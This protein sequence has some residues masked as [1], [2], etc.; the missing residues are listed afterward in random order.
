MLTSEK[1]LKMAREDTRHV[2]KIL[3]YLIVNSIN[4]AIMKKCK[5]FLLLNS[6]Q[7]T[8]PSLPFI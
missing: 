6:Y 8:A 7:H 1:E 2:G 4:G 5:Q 3:C